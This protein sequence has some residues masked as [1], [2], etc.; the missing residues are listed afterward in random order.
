V[1][2]LVRHLLVFVLHVRLLNASAVQRAVKVVEGVELER[3]SNQANIDV[4]GHLRE[5][6]LLI[7]YSAYLVLLLYSFVCFLLGAHMLSLCA[8]SQSFKNE[9]LHLK[10]VERVVLF[11]G[12]FVLPDVIKELLKEGIVRVLEQV[13]QVLLDHYKE[14][15]VAFVYCAVVDERLGRL[16]DFLHVLER[17][18]SA[19]RFS[20]LVLSV[21]V[22]IDLLRIQVVHAHARAVLPPNLRLE[23]ELAVAHGAHE[24]VASLPSRLFLLDAR[25]CRLLDRLRVDHLGG[26]EVLED[27]VLDFE[28]VRRKLLAQ[29]GQGVLF[30]EVLCQEDEQV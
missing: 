1:E 18:G 6:W 21:N 20:A 30:S 14:L 9:A 29:A 10:H 12:H 28:H 24:G 26:R 13:K 16:N 17:L 27:V 23:A 15:L 4:E 19:A 25:L 3:D 5:L 11:H 2:L 8:D 7:C 22:R